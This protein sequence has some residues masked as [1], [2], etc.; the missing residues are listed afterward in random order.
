MKLVTGVTAVFAATSV[1]ALGAAPAATAADT[2]DQVA[3]ATLDSIVS[4]DDAAAVA[5]FD[6]TMRPM[7]SAQALGQSWKTYQ[8]QFGAYQSHGAPEDVQRGALT[9]VNVPLQMANQP[10]QFRLTV[11]PNGTIAGLYFLKDGVPVP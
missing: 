7:L 2:P 4:G 5:P 10:G 1:L 6:D 9:V 3:L 11:H 8:E